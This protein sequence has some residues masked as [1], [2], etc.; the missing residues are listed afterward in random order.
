VRPKREQIQTGVILIH[1]RQRAAGRFSSMDS[2]VPT[3]W[4]LSRMRS[5][6]Y[7]DETQSSSAEVP[8]G[9][10]G[11]ISSPASSCKSGVPMVPPVLRG[12]QRISVHRGRFFIKSW[13]HCRMP[14]KKPRSWGRRT[15]PAD[16]P[17]FTLRRSCCEARL[18]FH[19]TVRSCS[20]SAFCLSWSNF[21]PRDFVKLSFEQIRVR[22]RTHRFDI[23]DD[24]FVN[25]LHDKMMYCHP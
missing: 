16:E 9:G 3:R 7:A 18:F 12:F 4:C 24:G 11:K 20:I 23:I 1:R 15:L 19:N 21:K 25:P 8:L 5:T 6:T 22:V 13:E 14:E 2:R 17:L 10:Q